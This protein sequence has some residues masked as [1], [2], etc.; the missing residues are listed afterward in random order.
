[1]WDVGSG[2]WDVGLYEL[3]NYRRRRARIGVRRRVRKYFGN[4]VVHM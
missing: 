3:V 2:M 1:M 4:A